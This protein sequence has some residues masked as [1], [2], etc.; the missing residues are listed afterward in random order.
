MK[1]GNNWHWDILLKQKG[2]AES[3]QRRAIQGFLISRVVFV[4]RSWGRSAIL[5]WNLSVVLLLYDNNKTDRYYWVERQNV[6]NLWAWMWNLSMSIW[7]YCFP[8]IIIEFMM[9]YKLWLLIKLYSFWILLE[10]LFLH[11]HETIES[12]KEWKPTL[13]F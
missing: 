11:E 12:I 2:F 9:A 1:M 6:I 13:I 4:I 10:I 5:W 8:C 7:S 3:S